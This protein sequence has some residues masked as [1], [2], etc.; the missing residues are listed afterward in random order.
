[1]TKV[2]Q[3]IYEEIY[4]QNADYLPQP[5]LDQCHLPFKMLSQQKMVRDFV[6]GKEINPIH[7]RIGIMGACNMRCNFCN[8][9]SHL[10]SDFYDLFSY[11][12]FIATDKCKV[13]L[14]EFYNLGGKAVTFC[15][16]GECTLHPGFVQIC[17]HAFSIG[18]KI[19]LI[20]NGSR[21][22]NPAIASCVEQT[23]TWIRIGLNAGNPMTFSK[24][25]HQQPNIFTGIL[26]SI[27]EIRRKAVAKDFRIG[28]NYVITG[29]NYK[30]LEMA[31]DA[32]FYSGAHYIR[33]EPEF[34]SAEGHR[35]LDDILYDIAYSLE[36]IN[37]RNWGEFEVSIP[38]LDR[39]PMDKTNNIEGDFS[40]CHYSRFVTAIGADSNLYPCPQV[41]L[42]SRYKIGNVVENGYEGILKGEPRREWEKLN[43]LRTDLCKSCFYRPQ[44]EL[45]EALLSGK[46][47]VEDVFEKYFQETPETLHAEFI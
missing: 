47:N 6:A 9:H 14:S 15:G 12:D 17:E 26:N 34:Y 39:G 32:A 46:I 4:P 45:L 36:K 41:H 10:E 8:F 40:R 37:S 20:T 19:G 24:V 44:N 2:D 5:Q 25:T 18:L 22:N 38:K 29:E 16:S 3:L 30:E 43:P 21:L 11:K 23:H 28:L 1:M 27:S 33:Y 35:M 13:L 42:N 31:A 7:L